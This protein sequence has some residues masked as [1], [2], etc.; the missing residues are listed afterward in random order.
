MDPLKH[1]KKTKNKEQPN[2]LMH[3]L[4]G[5]QTRLEI[6]GWGKELSLRTHVLPSQLIAFRQMT[7]YHG[8]Q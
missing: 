4:S 8:S 7:P 5:T 3:Q 6:G 1:T 2:S